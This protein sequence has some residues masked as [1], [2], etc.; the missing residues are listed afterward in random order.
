MAI[1]HERQPEVADVF[2]RVFGLGLAAQNHY[3]DHR[4]VGGGGGFF[5][6][7]V[8][9]F[10]RRRAAAGEA[11]A[12]A[13]EDIAKGFQFF[14]RR[15]VVDP[16]HAGQGR[17]FQCLGGGDVGGNHE[18]LDQFVRIEALADSDAVDGAIGRQIDPPLRH[19]Q[20]QRIPRR[21]ALEQRLIS[22]V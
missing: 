12:D 1:S 11:D 20:F 7:L 6:D 22:A 10:G 8:E 3:V 2:G 9:T 4:C 5:Q 16:V 15:L 21:S 18:F 17:L 19:F 14:L 13:F